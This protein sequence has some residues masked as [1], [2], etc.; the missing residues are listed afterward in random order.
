[1][2]GSIWHLDDAVDVVLDRVLGG[3]QLV[4]DVVQLAEGRIERGR[5][6]RAGR[7]GDQHDAVGLV[8]ELAERA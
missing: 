6:A 5:L 7:A 1:M 2:S 4:L 8:D 3:D